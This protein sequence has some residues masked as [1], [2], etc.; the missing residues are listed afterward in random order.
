[1]N[2]AVIPS[3]AQGTWMLGPF[4]IRA[5]ALC[6]IVGIMAGVWLAE[7]RSRARGGPPGLIVDIAVWAVP[8][9]IIGGRIYHV[10]TDPQLYF[11]AGRD[12]VRALY[13]WEGGLGI[14][15]AV[16]FGAF[17]AS[18]GAR[19][20]GVPLRQ[21]ADIL[22][23]AIPLG[24][25]IGRWGNW[26]NQEL[27]GRP[28]SLPWGL[29][30]SADRRPDGYEQSP[31]FHPTYLYESLWNLGLVAAVLLLDRRHRLSN[32][33]LFAVYVTGYTA[34]RFW[35]EYLR[36][37]PVNE[38]FGLRL[39]D[40]TALIF[41]IAAV[42][43]LICTRNSTTADTKRWPSAIETSP[44]NMNAHESSV[45]TKSTSRPPSGAAPHLDDRP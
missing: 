12:P 20:Y 24:Q 17:G 21:L 36:I 40:W 32:G 39:N 3:P 44:T 4:P 27:F 10:L 19:R 18:I 16:I 26:F 35:I 2:I 5:Y 23:P 9:G 29:E 38:F 13:I 25:A 14:W 34:G 45:P 1:M 11:A 22:A 8:F 42:I 43:Y 7:R 15:G 28:T 30:I 41:F 31:T 33:R 6:I 37:D